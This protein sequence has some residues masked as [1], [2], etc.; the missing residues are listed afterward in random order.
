MGKPLYLI[1]VNIN[2]KRRILAHFDRITSNLVPNHFAPLSEDLLR[3]EGQRAAEEKINDSNVTYSGGLLHGF[4]I[5]RK[6]ITKKGASFSFVNVQPYAINIE[7]GNPISDKWEAS[8]AEIQRWRDFKGIEGGNP[9]FVKVGRSGGGNRMPL[10]PYPEGVHFMEAGFTAILGD[11]TPKL[12][13][14]LINSM[15]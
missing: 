15:R 6:Y 10:L 13:T 5:Q 9:T 7:T 2:D 12:Q 11:L 14:A 1:D 3:E 4:V 8:A